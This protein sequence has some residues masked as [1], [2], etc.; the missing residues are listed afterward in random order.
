MEGEQQP[1]ADW[2]RI[3]RR[4]RCRDCADGVR[5]RRRERAPAGT[6]AH[7]RLRGAAGHHRGGGQ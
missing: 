5:R 2:R 7:G 4:D 3:G 6:G 1:A